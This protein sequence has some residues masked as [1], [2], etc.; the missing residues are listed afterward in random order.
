M[1]LTHVERQTTAINSCHCNQ[2]ETQHTERNSD[3]SIANHA[4]GLLVFKKLD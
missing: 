4:L 1:G 3:G 2:D